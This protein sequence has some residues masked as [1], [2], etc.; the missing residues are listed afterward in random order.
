VAIRLQREAVLV[1]E[2]LR[3]P[4]GRES[5]GA[6]VGGGRWFD[7]DYFEE[8]LFCSRVVPVAAS[9]VE[10][11]PDVRAL[12]PS[13][14]VDRN[15]DEAE[16]TAARN[17]LKEKE[18]AELVPAFDAEGIPTIVLKGLPM[19]ERFFGSGA[20]REVRDLDLLVPPESLESAERL[21]RESGY[22][23]FE[24]IH[25]RAYYRRHHFHVVYIRRGLG[26]D[27]VELH[28]NL[29][30]HPWNLRVDTNALFRASRP[31]EYGG[32]RVRVLAPRDE[33]AYL[34]A[35]LR[36]GLYVSLKRLVDLERM[37]RACRAETSAL[38][39][40]A[41]A[42]DWGIRD[43]VLASFYFLGRFWGDPRPD[44][45]FPSRVRRFASR[46]RGADFFGLGP[47][48]EIR[49]RIWSGFQFAGRSRRSFVYRLLWPDEDFR[50]KMFFA[51][52][53]RFSA[54]T[55]FRRFAA[56]LVSLADLAWNVALSGFRWKG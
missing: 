25:T 55:R 46:F 6:I 9:R 33:F 49:L 20:L 24:G 47:G 38:D 41:R 19:G 21:L 15:R 52:E 32:T 43:E 4:P 53:D 45:R 40:L 11:D 12:L 29:L 28:W 39:V 10:R 31:Y 56:G 22:T 42:G 16:K 35:A 5:L 3:S 8:I 17:L 27:V 13:R 26:I 2:L 1:R 36:M 23:L 50:A 54:R 34:C 30:P 37:E 18:L 7:W 44:L 51:E 48:R 14:L